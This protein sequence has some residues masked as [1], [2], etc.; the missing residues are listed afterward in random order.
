[1]QP[2]HESG[3][4]GG[5]T[6]EEV[7]RVGREEGPYWHTRV[8]VLLAEVHPVLQ[9]VETDHLEDTRV[10]VFGELCGGSQ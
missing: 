5:I 9:L 4:N 7:V 6:R 1:M 10:F 3:R 2:L 8:E